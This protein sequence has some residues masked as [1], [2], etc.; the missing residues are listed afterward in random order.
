M[1]LAMDKVGASIENH[2]RVQCETILVTGGR[3]DELSYLKRQAALIQPRLAKVLVM[4]LPYNLLNSVCFKW[5]G[6]LLSWFSLTTLNDCQKLQK[7]E[8]SGSWIFQKFMTLPLSELLEWEKQTQV[9]S[10]L[11]QE[12]Y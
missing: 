10:Y 2:K 3:M 8:R 7:G 11:S 1:A 9:I 5:D 6:N 12:F 4:L